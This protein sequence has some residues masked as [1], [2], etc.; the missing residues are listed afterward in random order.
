MCGPNLSE[1]IRVRVSPDILPRAK[2]KAEAGGISLSSLVRRAIEREV[3]GAG[4]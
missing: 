4:Q 2:A 3:A 1:V